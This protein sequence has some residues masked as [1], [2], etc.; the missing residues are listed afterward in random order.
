MHKRHIAIKCALYTFVAS[1]LTDAFN[2]W[3]CFFSLQ[4]THLSIQT[5]PSMCLLH[6][7]IFLGSKMGH[8]RVPRLSW[9]TKA[10]TKTHLRNFKTALHNSQVTMWTFRKERKKPTKTTWRSSALSAHPVPSGATR[11][12]AASPSIWSCVHGSRNSSQK[13]TLGISCPY[14]VVYDSSNYVIIWSWDGFVHWVTQVNSCSRCSLPAF[15]IFSQPKTNAAG[16]LF[17]AHKKKET[18]FQTRDSYSKKNK[19]KENIRMDLMMAHC[20]PN[21]GNYLA[22]ENVPWREDLSQWYYKSPRIYKS[23]SLWKFYTA[24]QS[25]PCLVTGRWQTGCEMT[26][27]LKNTLIL[28]KLGSH[29]INTAPELKIK[30]RYSTGCEMLILDL[31]ISGVTYFSIFLNEEH[32]LAVSLCRYVLLHG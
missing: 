3:A 11:L 18:G 28:L 6:V 19:G 13:Q 31:E 22:L 21:S 7:V 2:N 15:G 10:C 9:S 4:N 29:T 25:R 32:C 16:K 20:F 24:A 26:Q 1:L 5:V 8:L 12:H 30:H 27:K 17:Q 14:F 23:C